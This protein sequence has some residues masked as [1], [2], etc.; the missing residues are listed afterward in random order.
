M[1]KHTEEWLRQSD[2]DMDKNTALDMIARFR[3]GVEARGITP[4]K[5]ILYG[6][7]ADGTHREGS[8]IDVVIVSQDFAGKGYWERF[9]IL[10]DAIYEISHSSRPWR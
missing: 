1:E 9:G 6:S 10:A 5:V 3:R 4:Q 2:C 7:Y 8:D